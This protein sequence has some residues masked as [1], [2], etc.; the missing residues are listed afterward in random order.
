MTVDV[1]AVHLW[2]DVHLVDEMDNEPSILEPF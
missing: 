1:N 2:K